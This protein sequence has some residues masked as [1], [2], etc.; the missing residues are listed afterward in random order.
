MLS[1]KLHTEI[2][3]PGLKGKCELTLILFVLENNVKS[4]VLERNNVSSPPK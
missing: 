2:S 3:M 4:S 1:L